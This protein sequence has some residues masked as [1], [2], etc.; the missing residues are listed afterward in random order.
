M[1]RITTDH[2]ISRRQWN[3]ILAILVAVTSMGVFSESAHAQ[4]DFGRPSL[5]NDNLN[6]GPDGRSLDFKSAQESF[7]SWMIRSSGIFGFLLLL[8]AFVM[9]SIIM[10][11]AAQLRRENFLPASFIDEFEQQLQAKDYQGAFELAKASNSFLGRIIAA[12]LATLGTT[13]NYDDAIEQMQQVGEGES[14]AMQQKI[15]YLS[16]IGS[17]APMLGLLGTVQ[18]MVLAFWAISNSTGSPKPSELADGV[19]TALFT[20]MEGLA[21]AIPAIVFCSLFKNRLA[22][23]LM[24]CGFVADNFMKNFKGLTKPMAAAHPAMHPVSSHS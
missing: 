20:T 4:S 22:R 23:F 21:V 17:I 12:G 1:N 15:E 9:V 3:L 7:M 18:G 14:M 16:L 6:A 5:S 2:V 13:V 11:I 19:A 24:E 10:T 8:V